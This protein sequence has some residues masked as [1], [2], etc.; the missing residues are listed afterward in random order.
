MDGIALQTLRDEML[1][2]GRVI[3]EAFDKA[4]LRFDRHEEIAYEG[5][6]HQLCRLYNAFEQMS[7]RVAKAFENNIDD[8]QGWHTS[9]LNRLAIRIEGIRPAL[10]PPDLKLSLQELKAFRHVFVHAYELELDP[11]KLELLLKYARNVAGRLPLLVEDFI[12][13]VAREQQI[14]L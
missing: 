3:R 1:D 12:G 7:L 8:E 14:E 2:D 5:C 11:G 13:K 4:L 6:A 9:L 10:I